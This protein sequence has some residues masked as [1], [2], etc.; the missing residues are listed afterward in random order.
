MFNVHIF[1]SSSA[2][3][4]TD[5]VTLSLSLSQS[6]I[7]MFKTCQKALFNHKL[8][9]KSQNQIITRQEWQVNSDKSRVTC[10]EWQVKSL[11]IKASKY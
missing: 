8:H 10:L 9:V 11:C 1:Y 7:K 5:C 3:P 6:Q 2:P 4:H